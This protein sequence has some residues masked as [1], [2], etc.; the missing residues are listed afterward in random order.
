M[1][2]SETGILTDEELQKIYVWID[3]IP[4]S[5]PKRNIARDFSDGGQPTACERRGETGIGPWASGA[6]L[7]GNNNMIPA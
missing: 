3:S 6:A 4:L 1:A 7:Q 5:R 2:L